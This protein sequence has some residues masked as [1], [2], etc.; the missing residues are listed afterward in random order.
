MSVAMVKAV[1]E[2]EK[3]LRG[4]SFGAGMPIKHLNTFERFC[5]EEVCRQ[6]GWDWKIEGDPAV[7]YI[8]RAGAYR[9][10]PADARIRDPKVWPASY[11]CPWNSAPP[12]G[13]YIGRSETPRADYVGPATPVV[14]TGTDG[15]NDGFDRYRKAG[16]DLLNNRLSW[17]KEMDDRRKKNSAAPRS[18]EKCPDGAPRSFG[19]PSSPDVDDGTTFV[20]KPP[21]DEDQEDRDVAAWQKETAEKNRLHS[22]PLAGSEPVI[23]EPSDDDSVC[24]TDKEPMDVDADNKLLLEKA[25]A[26]DKKRK[27]ASERDA[28]NK[29]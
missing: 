27:A 16:E 1:Y 24:S 14:E 28:A 12:R 21:E 29:A 15:G 6:K 4:M 17:E 22:Q 26:E 11:P 10:D 9:Y 25:A 20:V 5:Y 3:R 19:P 8:L 23:N 13:A 18:E 2:A 7:F